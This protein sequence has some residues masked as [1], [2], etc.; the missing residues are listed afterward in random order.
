MT[1]VQQLAMDAVDLS[2]S[3]IVDLAMNGLKESIRSHVMG[4]EPKTY[5]EL[6]RA[7]DVAT[8]ISESRKNNVNNDSNSDDKLTNISKND[9]N[10]MFASFVESMRTVMQQEVMTVKT[11]QS[12]TQVQTRLSLQRV[13]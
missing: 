11:Q 7:I 9:V 6:R 5:E 1:I 2:Q 12:R 4:R 8:N 13:W 3:A 10:S